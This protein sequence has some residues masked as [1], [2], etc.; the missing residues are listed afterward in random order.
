MLHDERLNQFVQ[1]LAFIVHLVDI[2]D[3]HDSGQDFGRV[4]IGQSEVI[5][6]ELIQ[7]VLSD[8]LLFETI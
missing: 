3:L 6:P 1:I 4:G 7:K 8:E 2:E 5:L